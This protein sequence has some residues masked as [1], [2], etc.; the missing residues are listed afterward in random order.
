[1]KVKSIRLRL[2]LLFLVEDGFSMYNCRWNGIYS[3]RELCLAWYNNYCILEIQ[4][5]ISWSEV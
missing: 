2:V 4:D 5:D 1:M 3:T